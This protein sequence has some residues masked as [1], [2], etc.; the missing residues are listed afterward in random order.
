MN[1]RR[2]MTL[3]GSTLAMLGEH[4]QQ[5]F[6]GEARAHAVGQQMVQMLEES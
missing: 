2:F 3:T 1:R 4:L 6:R 5:T